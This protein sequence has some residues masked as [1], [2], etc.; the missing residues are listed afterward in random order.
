MKCPITRSAIK[1]QRSTTD[2]CFV[3]ILPARVRVLRCASDSTAPSKQPANGKQHTSGLVLLIQY[4][5]KRQTFHLFCCFATLKTL[6]LPWRLETTNPSHYF[7]RHRRW[8]CSSTQPTPRLETMVVAQA[9][10][11]CSRHRFS[12]TTPIHRLEGRTHRLRQQQRPRPLLQKMKCFKDFVA[13]PV[14]G[15]C[16]LWPIWNSKR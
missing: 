8:H 5:K 10:A 3:P 14:T 15:T 6:Y 16:R 12:T 11:K 1:S 7:R 4:I 2:I 13:L 9:R